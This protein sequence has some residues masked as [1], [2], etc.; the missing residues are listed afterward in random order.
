MGTFP[1]D[2]PLLRFETLYQQ[3]TKAKEI[4][5]LLSSTL[6]VNGDRS[7][8]EELLSRCEERYRVSKNVCKISSFYDLLH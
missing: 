8:C 2:K 6:I 3:T 5:P 1:L 4:V 7:A